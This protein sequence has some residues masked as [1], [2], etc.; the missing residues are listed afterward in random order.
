MQTVHNFL[1]RRLVIPPV[2]IQDIDVRRPQLLQAGFDAHVHALHVIADMVR[3]DFDMLVVELVVMGV[4]RSG[5]QI[6][7]EVMIPLSNEP[8]RSLILAYSKS[9]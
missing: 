4:L 6:Y 1:N 7:L 8:L 9:Q 2:H 5:G 3:L